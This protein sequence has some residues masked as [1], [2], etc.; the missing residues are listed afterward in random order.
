LCYD[1]A[2]CGSGTAA[3]T[4]A[5]ETITNMCILLLQH[6]NASTKLENQTNKMTYKTSKGELLLLQNCWAKI[7]AKIADH[8]KTKK[9]MPKGKKI[10]D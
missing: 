4:A 10:G 8:N 5:K 6:C 3:A 9:N 2:P 1:K 7:L